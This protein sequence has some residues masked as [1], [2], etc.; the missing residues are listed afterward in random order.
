[1][2]S[3]HLS[4]IGP[5]RA[6][7][8]TASEPSWVPVD[9]CLLPSDERPMRL[10]AFE[11]LFAVAV[12]S[13]ARPEPTRL[14]FALVPEPA[15]AARAAALAAREADCCGFFTFALTAAQGRLVLE[16]AVPET[17]AGVLDG[18]AAQSAAAGA[19]S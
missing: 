2:T 7:D 6:P 17:R 10:D 16:V 12:R 3:P 14:R 11:D 15:V 8:A 18:L 19:P 1:M 5:D 4:A 13:I 9:A